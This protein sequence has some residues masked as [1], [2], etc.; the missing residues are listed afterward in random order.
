[1]L[2]LV[3]AVTERDF[4]PFLRLFACRLPL[5]LKAQALLFFMVVE[6]R[7]RLIYFTF[8]CNISTIT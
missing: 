5:Y 1:M 7:S 4:W 3:T 6:D 2:A 8:C